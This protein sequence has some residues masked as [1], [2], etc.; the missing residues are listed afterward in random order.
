ME[1]NE[2]AIETITIDCVDPELVSRFWI[3]LLGYE[4]VPNHTNSIQTGHPS[5]R[6]PRMLFTPAGEAKREKNRIHFDLR[7]ENQSES[8]E[9]A[10]ALGAH[11]SEIG[12][13]GEESW[14][15]LRDPEGNEF[16]ILQSLT[17]FERFSEGL[18][19]SA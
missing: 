6:G 10:L 2:L 13:T 16:C 3:D 11:I 15:V 7:P 1:R 5:N 18:E 19:S 17:D 8:V 9:R 14:V 4:V 12:Q